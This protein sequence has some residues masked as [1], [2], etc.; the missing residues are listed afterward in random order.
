MTGGSTDNT[1]NTNSNECYVFSPGANTWQQL[2]NKP[3]SWLTG[4][5]GTVNMGNNI[6]KLICA[7]GYASSYLSQNEILSD[8]INPIG[9]IQNNNNLPEKFVLMQN[10]PNPF[11]PETTINFDLPKN[12]FVELKIFDINGKEV[13]VPHSGNLLAGSYELKWSAAGFPSGVYFYRIQAENFSDT[14]KMML[15]K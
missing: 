4:Q 6:W 1:F 10:Y 9:V 5:S 14:K 3:T 12:S 2:P 11:N 15:I 13:A 8:T 7:S